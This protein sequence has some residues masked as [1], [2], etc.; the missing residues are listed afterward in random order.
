MRCSVCRPCH[1]LPCLGTRAF[2]CVSCTE[3]TDVTYIK[4]TLL[5][6]FSKSS[7]FFPSCST[8][9]SLAY[10]P[11]LH[12]ATARAPLPSRWLHPPPTTLSCLPREY[13]APP[14]WTPG[15]LHPRGP[16]SLAPDCFPTL[17]YNLCHTTFNFIFL[18]LFFFS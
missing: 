15:V 3:R 2:V 4:T 17:L 6:L 13:L 18:F 12:M 16:Q 8:L 1:R 10:Q 7:L 14:V 5:T 11:E 9:N